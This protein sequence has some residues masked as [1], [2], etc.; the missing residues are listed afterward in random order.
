M[1]DEFRCAKCNKKLKDAST[2]SAAIV[3]TQDLTSDDS[4]TSLLWCR[5]ETDADG[6]VTS[7]GCGTK[8]LKGVNAGAWRATQAPPNAPVKAKKSRA[9]NTTTQSEA[10]P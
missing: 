4:L 2:G 6:K 10:T 1:T 9:K 7:E 5:D 3:V 8:V